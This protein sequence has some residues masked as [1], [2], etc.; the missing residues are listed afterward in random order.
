M[1]TP[2]RR[3]QPRVTPAVRDRCTKDYLVVHRLNPAEQL[4]KERINVFELRV[5]Q[6]PKRLPLNVGKRT[7]VGD[8]LDEVSVYVHR[9]LPGFVSRQLE[10]AAV[11][12]KPCQQWIVRPVSLVVVGVKKNG[13]D[14]V[15]SVSSC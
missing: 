12:V 6:C 4:S 13:S 7:A 3:V 14:W 1:S 2:R 9:E 10:A 11:L 15:A 8:L 5:V